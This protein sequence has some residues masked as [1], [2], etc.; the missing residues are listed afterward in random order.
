MLLLY[1]RQ[2]ETTINRNLLRDESLASEKVCTVLF[3]RGRLKITLKPHTACCVCQYCTS[4][5]C[6]CAA[7]FETDAWRLHASGLG[8]KSLASKSWK[9]LFVIEK[10]AIRNQF[11]VKLFLLCF[12]RF[13]FEVTFIKTFNL[14]LY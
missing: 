12:H 1:L 10:N 13:A 8:K 4:N 7:K 9:K 11:F 5:S 14:A 3:V 6:P 2:D